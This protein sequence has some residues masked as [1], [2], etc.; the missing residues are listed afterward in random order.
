M[1]NQ[2]GITLIVLV[3]TIIVL[4]I[5]VGVSINLFVGENGII[6]KAQQGKEM[7][8][9]ASAK[10][11]LEMNLSD[12]Q[13][14]K[15]TDKNY[16]NQAYIDNY[17]QKQGMIVNADI[18]LVDQYHF[19]IDR[20]KLSIVQSLGKGQESQT[21]KVEVTSRIAAD[22]TKAIVSIVI[23]NTNSLKKIQVNGENVSIPA[24]IEGKYSVEK[25]VSNN[26]ETTVYVVDEKEEYKVAKVNIA[27][28]SED[29]RI[30]NKE[31][32]LAFRDRV[33]QGA[34]YEGRTITLT[35]D[36]DLQGSESNQ[37]IPIGK[38]TFKGTFDGQNHQIHNM[39]I[40]EL[41]E[42]QGFFG[43]NDGTIKNIQVDGTMICGINAGGI[44][45]RNNARIENCK[46]KVTITSTGYNVGG[47]VGFSWVN[48]VTDT[49]ANLGNIKATGY[50]SEQSQETFVGG[51]VGSHHAT[52]TNSYNTGNIEGIRLAG[53][54][55]G[56]LLQGEI[57][58]C[59]NTGNI[60][61]KDKGAGGICGYMH[62]FS[63]ATLGY[64]K[65]NNTYTIGNV[66]GVGAIGNSIGYI[67]PKEGDTNFP[68]LEGNY[69]YCLIKEGITAIGGTN[70]SDKVIVEEKSSEELK[71]I[72]LTLGKGFK[73]DINN[74]NN[75]YPLLAWQ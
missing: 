16:N 32:L 4:I 33:N 56:G 62:Y 9:Q 61:T 13:I 69:N 66:E 50:T 63:G 52:V 65:I 44:A 20:E 70:T 14:S 22:Y 23:Q 7:N 10:E 12:L 43:I 40:H 64:T 28:V 68:L 75:G 47:I 55:V 31:E 39:Y 18:V 54:I 34:T 5:L 58:N 41:S 17:L 2:K 74:R 42:V 26:G 3:I 8:E 29:I 60:K 27:G 72:A 71:N 6:T 51:I 19:L 59:Y 38:E 24:L 35:T 1:R 67:V 11:K 37:W 73:A 21:I 48:S 45:A 30:T 49:C 25:E 36:I 53:G 57:Q 46:S 15:S